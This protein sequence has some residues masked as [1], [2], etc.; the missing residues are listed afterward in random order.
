M[1]IIHIFMNFTYFCTIL[2]VKINIIGMKEKEDKNYI[3]N[4]NNIGMK[5]FF[6]MP[7]K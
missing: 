3:F 6:S 7:K 2:K 5:L 4:E 1:A